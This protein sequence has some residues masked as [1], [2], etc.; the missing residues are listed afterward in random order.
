MVGYNILN[1]FFVKQYKYMLE[2]MEDVILVMD[3]MLFFDNRV[4]FDDIVMNGKFFWSILDYK[5]CCYLWKNY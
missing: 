3:L 2:F 1:V 4:K 5:Y